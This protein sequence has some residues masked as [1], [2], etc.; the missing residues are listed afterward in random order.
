[1][2]DK[3]TVSP[4]P[5]AGIGPTDGE[6]AL[7]IG[8]DAVQAELRARRVGA[9]ARLYGA[10]PAARLAS[11]RVA[12]IGIGGVGSWAAEALARSGVG[13]LRLGD[14]DHI[15]DSN[16][17][18]QVHALADEVGRAKVEAMAARIAAMD[19]GCVVE[20]VDDFLTPDNVAEMVAGCDAVLDC[21]DDGRAKTALVVHARRHGIRLIVC[22]AAGGKRD[23]TRVQIDDL[24]RVRNDPLLARLRTTLRREH[25]FPAGG[26]KRVAPF[27]VV[28]VFVDEPPAPAPVSCA[29]GAALACAG[30]GSAVHVTASVGFAAA[31]WLINAVTAAG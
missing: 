30:Y 12:V 23:A 24:A 4:P 17:N 3:P 1:M 5:Q 13:T 9:L 28:A 7:V 18:R 20:T 19:V 27:G 6:A 14:L 21:I 31:G 29:P 10:E 11:L 8:A 2:N 26:A 25:G 15:A 16:I 22:G